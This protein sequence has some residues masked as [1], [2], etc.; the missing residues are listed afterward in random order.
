MKYNK[1]KINA[2]CEIYGEKFKLGRFFELF[3]VEIG[4]KGQ[5]GF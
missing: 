4:F 2:V 5:F 3:E 1:I